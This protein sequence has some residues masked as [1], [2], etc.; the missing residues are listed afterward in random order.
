MAAA[1][2]KRDHLV[3]GKRPLGQNIQHLAAHIAGGADHRDLVTHCS[4]SEKGSRRRAG[5]VTAATSRREYR[6]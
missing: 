1:R 6:H 4:L 2:G 5:A 3:G